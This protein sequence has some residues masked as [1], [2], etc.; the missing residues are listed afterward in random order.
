[1]ADKALD[2]LKD[3]MSPDNQEWVEQLPKERQRELLKE[4]QSPGW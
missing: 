2:T 4:W 1:M 3:Q